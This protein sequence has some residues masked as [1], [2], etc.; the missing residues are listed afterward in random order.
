VA[1]ANIQ[2]SLA[3]LGKAFPVGSY[4][5]F[6]KESASLDWILKPPGGTLTHQPLFGSASSADMSLVS[7][8]AGHVAGWG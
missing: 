6:E 2:F 4:V 5:Y 8:N 3:E 1:I 7:A